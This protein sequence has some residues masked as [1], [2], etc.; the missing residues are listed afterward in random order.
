M[1][2][3]RSTGKSFSF[4]KICGQR[5]KYTFHALSVQMPGNEVNQ[6]NCK[7]HIRDLKRERK[8]QAKSEQLEVK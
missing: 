1:K 8:T 7:P 6:V 4:F 3:K 5:E 2:G